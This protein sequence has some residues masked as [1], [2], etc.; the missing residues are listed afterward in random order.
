MRS[1]AGIFR[2]TDSYVRKDILRP[3]HM[4]DVLAHDATFF[5]ARSFSNLFGRGQP[6]HL[7]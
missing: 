5:V 7:R 2:I 6:L 3:V 1:D 4:L